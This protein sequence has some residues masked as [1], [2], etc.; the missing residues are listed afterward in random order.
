VIPAGYHRKN[1]TEHAGKSRRSKGM[2][3]NRIRVGIVGCGFITQ[4]THIPAFRKCKESQ[5]VALCDRNGDLVK[6]VAGKFGISR[7]Y[8]DFGEMLTKEKLDAIDICTNINTHAPLAIQ[9]MDAGCHVLVEKPM[10]LNTEEANAV[11]S[12]S[13]ENGVQVCVIHNMLFLPT[14]TKIKSILNKGTIGN[15][16][17]VEIVQ[18]TPPWDFP[19]VADSTHW[20]HKLPGGIFG[21]NLPHPLYLMREFLGDLEL[22]SVYKDKCGNVSH[23][24]VDEVQILVKGTNGLGT[25]ISSCNYPS[26]WQV[27]IFGSKKCLHA[28]LNNSYVIVC[29][30]KSK[31]GKGIASLYARENLSRSFQIISSTLAMGMKFF[32]GRYQGHTILINHF[33]ESIRNKT[34]SPVTAEDGRDVV[35][36]W[37]KAVS[38]I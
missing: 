33:V 14:V 3:K 37:E 27:D 4:E 25:I 32:V 5:I 18:V 12:A 16:F 17:R 19:P 36:L 7:Y 21:D 28:N 26:L 24:P 22:L 15:P 23:L 6:N 29:E 34:S 30:G 20:Y 10:A 8:T 35:G 38:K 13:R 11:V 1:S 9:A 2:G 31:A